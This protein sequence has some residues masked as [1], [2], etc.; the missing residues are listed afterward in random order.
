MTNPNQDARVLNSRDESGT[1]EQ[2]APRDSAVDVLFSPYFGSTALMQSIFADKLWTMKTGEDITLAYSVRHH[3]K[4]PVLI[5]DDVDD[6]PGELE[7]LRPV[8][9]ANLA[10]V[11]GGVNRSW[12]C[13]FAEGPCGDDNFVQMVSTED[14]S[15]G[16]MVND[17]QLKGSAESPSTA[18]AVTENA[19]RQ[20]SS[21][22][23]TIT[24]CH[25]FPKSSPPISC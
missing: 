24:S 14:R 7:D 11:L 9:T 15:R 25:R 21:R 18:G 22:M 10:T 23:H 16:Y 2:C 6:Y 12:S 1:C 5:F 8:F 19:M 13:I 4:V 3:A 20:K 17:P